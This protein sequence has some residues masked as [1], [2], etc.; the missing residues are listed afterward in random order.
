MATMKD[1]ANKAGVSI[2]T[3]S[4]ILNG[5]VTLV[6]REETRDAVFKAAK[7]LD[8]KVKSK[9]P[10]QVYSFGIVQWISSYEE[11]DDTYYYNIRMSVENYCILHNIEI[12][13]YY[14]E[15][16]DEVFSDPNL[17]GLLC[18][19]KFSRK[20]ASKLN[21]K[22]KEIV[23]V[24]S[25]PDKL[26]YNAVYSDFKSGT[27]MAMDYFI[28]KG[29][30]RIAYVGGHEYLDDYKGELYVDSRE[31]IY[32]EYMHNH[33]LLEYRE[34]DVYVGS[35]SAESG[36][37]AM[38]KILGKQSKPTAVLCGND[39]IAIGV[40][41]ALNESSIEEKISIIGFNN[42]PMAQFYNPPLTTIHIDTKYKGELACRLL[43]S[44][45]E[46]GNKTPIKI[47]CSVRLVERESV[48][49]L[50]KWNFGKC[51]VNIY[52]FL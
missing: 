13:R 3:V 14:R 19:G 48:Y 11:K 26:K 49:D 45:I 12:K 34:D 21:A 51:L 8:Y 47:V 4:R 46:D 15:N 27:E 33:P 30:R 18:I 31:R 6:V 40:L 16:L 52:L 43:L 28:E 32:L 36:Y 23:F 24:D 39:V 42:S 41:S 29:H 17:D 25:N 35:F 20:L 9:K 5:D 10:N 50:I 37:D 2:A 1:I 44:L 38:N 7:S 22:F